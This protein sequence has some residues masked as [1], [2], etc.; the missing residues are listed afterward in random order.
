MKEFV[1]DDDE[2]VRID[3][4]KSENK[5]IKKKINALKEKLSQQ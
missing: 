4:F 5:D 1:N 3:Y 2:D